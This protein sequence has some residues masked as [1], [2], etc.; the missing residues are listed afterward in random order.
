MRSSET[1]L[2]VVDFG[3]GYPV[4][5]LASLLF[6]G[7]DYSVFMFHFLLGFVKIGL[8]LL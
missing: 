7:L 8:V 6:F 4:M 2:L 1:Y 3:H 5:H